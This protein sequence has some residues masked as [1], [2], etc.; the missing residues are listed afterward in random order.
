MDGAGLDRRELHALLG[1]TLASGLG[2]APSRQDEDAPPDVL[3]VVGG[4][5]GWTDVV[6]NVPTPEL[7]KLIRRGRTFRQAFSYPAGT[8]TAYLLHFGRHPRRDGVFE[9]LPYYGDGAGE[10]GGDPGDAPRANPELPTLPGVLRAAGYRTGLFG[11]WNLGSVP[12]TERARTPERFGY[13]C[14]RAGVPTVLVQGGGSGYEDWLRVDDGVEQRSTEYQTTALFDAWKDWWTTT[15]GPRFAL[16]SFPVA[17]GPFH[18][19]PRALVPNPKRTKGARGDDREGRRASFEDMVQSLDTVLGQMLE[20]VSDRTIVVFLADN[21]TPIQATAKGQSPEQVKHSTFDG[22]VHVP[23]VLAGPG[24]E[25]GPTDALVSLVDLPRTLAELAGALPDPARA[26]DLWPDSVSLRRLLR[27]PKR[28][29]R[30][31]VYGE[32]NDREFFV[33]SR[34]YKLRLVLDEEG[35]TEE[36]YNL[37]RDPEERYPVRLEEPRNRAAREELRTELRALFG[38]EHPAL[39]AGDREAESETPP[40]LPEEP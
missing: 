40:Q 35:W 11:K 16:C 5:L 23:L 1:V 15:E 34:S 26:A 6:P 21:G 36:L 32:A 4:D 3:V 2:F 12:D 33:R 20:L 38:E 17:H 9:G 13:E 22:G 8:L 31:T 19:P 29:V 7:A 30:K 27:Q 24:I 28:S 14:W 10:P 18:D 39:A 37:K 25:P